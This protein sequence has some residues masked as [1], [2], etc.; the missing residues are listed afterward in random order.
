[1]ELPGHESWGSR[2]VMAMIDVLNDKSRSFG[3][4]YLPWKQLQEESLKHLQSS[5][6]L[7]T[8]FMASSNLQT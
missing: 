7:H 1:M 2:A 8:K 3:H 4:T 6:K 5:G